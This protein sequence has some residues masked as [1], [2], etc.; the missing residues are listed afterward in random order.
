M[1]N[2]TKRTSPK[3]YICW[4]LLFSAIGIGIA[5]FAEVAELKCSRQND[6]CTIAR[7]AP[8]RRE[9]ETFRLSG[10]T[11]AE[12]RC[13]PSSGV[14]SRT[15][16]LHIVLRTT[17]GDRH[18]LSYDT[19]LWLGSMK[20]SAEEINGFVS[21]TKG[22]TLRIRQDNRIIVLF[23]L[24]PFSVDI[25]VIWLWRK[26]IREEEYPQTVAENSGQ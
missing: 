20:K 21:S 8:L 3:A 13:Y 9:R 7:T 14:A 15:T 26:K 12:L 25:L 17:E 1:P 4:L 10:V 11:G 18:L 22:E 2:D 24:F 19:G 16:V 5:S 23:S 6:A